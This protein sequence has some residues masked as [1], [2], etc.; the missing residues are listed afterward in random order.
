MKELLR[1]RG[2]LQFVGDVL[3]G[4]RI[5]FVYIANGH[6]RKWDIP[7]RV[8]VGFNGGYGGCR[9]ETIPDKTHQDYREHSSHYTGTRPDCQT[10]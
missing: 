7:N 10:Q 3:G 5:D 8:V 4:G 9:L 1:R 2:D 6:C